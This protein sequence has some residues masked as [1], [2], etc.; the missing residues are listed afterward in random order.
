MTIGYTQANT[1]ISI[2][3]PLG[4]D[5]LLLGAFHGEESL[6]A[7]FHFSLDMS[8]EKSDLD[9]TQIVGKGVTIS[10]TASGGT[11]RYLHGLMTR[12][13]QAGTTSRLTSYFGE[14]RPWLWMLNLSSDQ[15]I[16]QAKS[17]L[18]IVKALFG[19][20]GYTVF[21]DATTGTYSPR[22]YC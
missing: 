3:T 19:E 7:P 15:R 12:F 22:D 10:I 18:D 20:L 9:F 2:S 5:T 6:S 13:V 16:Y 14:I 1:Y 4:A 21:R 17:T 11:T 8:S